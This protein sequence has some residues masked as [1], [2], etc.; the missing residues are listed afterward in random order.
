[1]EALRFKLNVSVEIKNLNRVVAAI[2]SKSLSGPIS[3]FIPGRY[4]PGRYRVRL[5]RRN[6]LF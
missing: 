4:F 5:F 3:A 2:L 6:G 1:V